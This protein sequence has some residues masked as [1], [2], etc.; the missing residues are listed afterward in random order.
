[1]PAPVDPIVADYNAS[2]PK[3]S[4]HG[5]ISRTRLILII[6]IF[7]AAAAVMPFDGH[8]SRAFIGV[9]LGG[10]IKRELE[11]IQQFG[12]ISSLVL[13]GLIVLLVDRAN[14]RR[15]ADLAAVMVCVSV[16]VS[17]I[18]MLVGRPRP[19]Y[20]DPFSFCLPWKTYAVDGPSDSLAE[21][22]QIHAWQIGAARHH[23]LWSMPS[24]HTAA[25][26]AFAVF[27]VRAYPRLRPLAVALAIVVGIC[28]VVLRA[29]YPSD[30]LV[31]AGVG[32]AMATLVL[33]LRI[34][35]R[36]VKLIRR[37]PHAA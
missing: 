32:W 11:A 21:K 7:A 25:A 3:A 35:E 23:E 10:D 14:F 26:V 18:K 13:F 30:V 1:M 29:H 28:R 20:D 16:S 24:S 15:I 22:V 2:G 37:E 36:A 6:S 19:K 27:L 5:T 33:N 8:I 12:G 34:G 4:N 17:V 9:K 31:A